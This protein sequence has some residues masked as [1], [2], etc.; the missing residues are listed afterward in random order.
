MRINFVKLAFGILMCIKHCWINLETYESLKTIL[1][2][3]YLMCINFLGTF[4]MYIKKHWNKLSCLVNLYN[5]CSC[6]W[7][8]HIAKYHL[9]MYIHIL[10]GTAL[11]LILYLRNWKGRINIALKFTSMLK[12]KKCRIGIVFVGLLF[13]LELPP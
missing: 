11:D 2:Y 4:L 12:N 10:I 13:E 3:E 9:Y 8:P 6:T 7:Y 1:Y 5:T